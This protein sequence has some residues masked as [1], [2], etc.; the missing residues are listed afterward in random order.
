MAQVVS[1]NQ[2]DQGDSNQQGTMAN[3]ISAVA[4]DGSETIVFESYSST[5]KLQTEYSL[6]TNKN[7]TLKFEEGAILELEDVGTPPPIYR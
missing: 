3:L 5:Y 6:P 1:K 2:N 4:P 7:I